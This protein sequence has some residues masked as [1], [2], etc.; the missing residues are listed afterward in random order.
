[1][2]MSLNDRIKEAI[3]G[4]GLKPSE[5]ARAAGVSRG[6]VTQW[7]NGLTRSLKA[8]TAAKLEIATGYRASWLVTGKGPKKVSDNAPPGSVFQQLT[9]DEI[10]FLD[11]F[12]RLTDQD[13]A[14]YTAEIAARAEELQA[15][16]D[17]HIHPIK[18][19]TSTTSKS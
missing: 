17:Q 11:N 12:R 4:A 19:G 2:S 6:A 9:Q 15:Y 1:M 13:R 8:E 18:N 5:L 16:L 14:R 3:D 10:D 7:T